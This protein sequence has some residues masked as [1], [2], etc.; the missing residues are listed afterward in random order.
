MQGPGLG[1]L[2]FLVLL[3][4]GRNL[5]RLFCAVVQAIVKHPYFAWV[6]FLVF[7]LV[8]YGALRVCE[9]LFGNQF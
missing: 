5:F 7:L 4:E 1:F 8:L 6:W 9:A 2:I 3:I